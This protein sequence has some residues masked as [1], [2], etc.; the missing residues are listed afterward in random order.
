MEFLVSAKKD[1]K[2]FLEE[3]MEIELEEIVEKCD[4]IVQKMK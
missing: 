3:K 4:K 2:K 1:E